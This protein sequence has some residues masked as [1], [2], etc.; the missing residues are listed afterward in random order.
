VWDR[1]LGLELFPAAVLRKEMD[2]YR[3]IQKENP[4]GL[5]LD[6]RQTYTKLDW[7]LWTATLTQDRADFVALVDP[8]VKFLNETPD[9]VP[10]T[11]W[12]VN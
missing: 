4:Y 2:Y 6:N 1:I 12:Y 3:Q 7:V 9:R 8:V 11:D 5:P 10:M